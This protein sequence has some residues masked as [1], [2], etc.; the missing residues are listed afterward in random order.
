M[1]PT[2]KLY[3]DQAILINFEQKIDPAINAAVIALKNAIEAAAISGI[4]FMIPAYCSLTIGYNP[5]IIEYKILVKVI[6]QIIATQPNNPTDNPAQKEGRQL[7]IPVC[8]ELPYALDLLELSETKELSVDK[9]IELH[10]SQT[11][12]VYMLGFMPG[13]TFMGKIVPALECK[14]KLSPRLQV[15][16]SSVGIAGFQTGIYPTTSPG[17][18]QILGR[19]PLKIFNPQKANPFLFQAGDE[20]TFYPIAKEEFLSIEASQ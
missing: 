7:K 13:F 20:V 11:Y 15:P 12:K 4:T 14:R 19:T 8:Y 2:I 3:G 10:T 1:I 6:E 5:A 17:G 9:I 16:A 18:W